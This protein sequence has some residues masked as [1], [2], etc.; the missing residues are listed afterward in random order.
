MR[1]FCKIP[2]IKGYIRKDRGEKS[3]VKQP[4]SF[5]E[6]D[7]IKNLNNIQYAFD[8]LPFKHYYRKNNIFD[9]LKCSI[10]TFEL[11]GK[12]LLFDEF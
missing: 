2:L 12:Y 3:N 11:V 7:Q 9:A 6:S 8:P 4:K 10:R 1:F 5:A